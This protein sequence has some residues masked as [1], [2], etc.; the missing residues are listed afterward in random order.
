MKKK[1]RACVLAAALVALVPC[2]AFAQGDVQYTSPSG[3]KY[4][5]Q[6]DAK[7]NVTQLL[8]LADAQAGLWNIKEAIRIYD[9]AL[10][11]DPNNATAYQQRGHRQLSIREL[12]KARADLEKAASM[13][14]KLVGAWYYL[15]VL[16]YAEGKFDKAAADF[17]KN[18]AL[19]DDDFTKAIGTVDWLYMSYRRGK[20]D[21][22]A[23]ALLDRVTP[24]LKIE[25]SA[26]LYFNRTLFYKGLKTPDEL[27]AAATTDI[28]RTTLSYGIGNYYWLAG[29]TQKAREYMQRAVST[30]AW[31]G[32]AFI[33]AEK[34]LARLR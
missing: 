4:Y 31:V 14:P 3:K 20:Q 13:D 12:Q 19:Q 11:L 22:K 8:A 16:D 5:A 23:K 29:D 30:T 21:E 27:L 25:G 34:D 6:A 17:E 33:A 1:M 32:L 2:A 24:E 9:R 15:G 26:R 10:A 7:D 28:E 18:L